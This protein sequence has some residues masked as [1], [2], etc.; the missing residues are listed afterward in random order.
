MTANEENA[1]WNAVSCLWRRLRR[2][3]VV[4]KP[5][6]IQPTSCCMSM[7][8]PWPDV[9]VWTQK[10]YWVWVP[11]TIIIGHRVAKIRVTSCCATICWS[12]PLPVWPNLLHTFSRHS[13]LRCTHAYRQT[14]MVPWQEPRTR[15]IDSGSRK[16]I[17]PAGIQVKGPVTHKPW[18]G[19]QICEILAYRR[20]DSLHSPASRTDTT[21]THLWLVLWH[22][23]SPGIGF[24][25]CSTAPSQAPRR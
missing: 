17:W 3:A 24:C 15:H 20:S 21:A 1:V 25:S 14:F 6:K 12:R 16:S 2:H 9:V 7:L 10:R 13:P 11:S 5:F 4:W 23:G 22:W 18:R 8:R 19:E